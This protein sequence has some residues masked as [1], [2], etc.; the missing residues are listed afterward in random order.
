MKHAALFALLFFAFDLP[1]AI[2]SSDSYV[3]YIKGL[4]QERA[5]H[6]K[7]ALSEYEKVVQEDP[8]ALEAYRDIA[9][10]HL[11]LGQSDQALAAAEKARDLAPQDPT[12][13]LFLGNVLVTK[14]ELAKAADSYEQALKLDPNNL[15]ALENLGNYYSILDPDKGLLYYQRYLVLEP[16]DAEM[17]YQVGLV[18]EKKSDVRAAI[19]DFKKSI[20]IAPE[21]PAPHLALAEI[22]EVHKSTSDA[23]REYSQAVQLEP[24]NPTI[25]LRLGRLYYVDGQMQQAQAQ[26]QAARDLAPDEPTVY[27]WLTRVSEDL[28]Q[29]PDAVRNA[30]KSYDL[31]RET[32]FLPL[33][34]YYLTLDQK[35]EEATTWLEKARKADPDNANTLLLLGMDYLDLNKSENARDVLQ[36]GVKVHPQDAQ[37]HFQLGIADDQLSRWDDAAAEFQQVLTL[38]PQNAAA[39]NY[40]GY[41]WADRG[42]RLPEAEKLLRQAVALEPRNGAYLDSL[43][44]VRFKQGDLKEA[45]G[46]LEQAYTVMPDALIYDHAGDVYAALNDWSKAAEVWTKSLELD[47]KNDKVRQKLRDATSR[48]TPGSDQRKY[49]KYVEGNFRQVRDLRGAV[50]VKAHW[51]K[52]SVAVAGHLFYDRPD[53]L[54]LRL[55]QPRGNPDVPRLEVR[56]QDVRVE[57]PEYQQGLQFIPPQPLRDLRVY[58]SAEILQPLDGADVQ[59][60]TTSQGLHFVSPGG[61]EAWIDTTRGVLT[62]LRKPNAEGGQDVLR[63]D[64][65]KMVDG[66]WLPSQL[67]VENRRQGWR[68]RMSISEWAVND[69]ATAAMFKKP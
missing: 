48:V 34:A 37:L 1:Y 36:H 65:Y 54:L 69:A 51:K 3:H 67:R 66:I 15:R 7:E 32:Q 20:E 10:L 26:F 38:D 13:Y 56:G 22:Y 46:V 61:E 31:T 17:Y 33:I 23:I 64:D 21:Q 44:W 29:W 11:R 57:P 43:G 53:E 63:F 35:V 4:S 28:K 8:Q 58:F 25:L 59:T 19:E 27:Y 55:D 45:A 41:S 14:G 6:I 39:M 60:S 52:Q 5:G 2:A 47:A 62:E 50:R 40:L 42:M 49:L 30:E 16:D 12:S 24:R 68:A 9:S 18:Q